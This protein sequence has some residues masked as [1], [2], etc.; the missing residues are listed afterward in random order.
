MPDPS[1]RSSPD[2][3][4]VSE[5]VRMEA[6]AA[7]TPKEAAADLLEERPAGASEDAPRWRGAA[8]GREGV[9]LTSRCPYKAGACGETGAGQ[10]F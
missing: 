10:V 7:G 5:S 9:A 1:P 2:P 6:R 8:D 3:G 4:R